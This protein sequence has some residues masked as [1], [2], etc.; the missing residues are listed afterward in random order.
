MTIIISTLFE[1]RV[2][3]ER[4]TGSKKYANSTFCCCKV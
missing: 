2:E 3:Q 1:G 4:R